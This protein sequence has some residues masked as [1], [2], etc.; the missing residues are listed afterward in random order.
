MVIIYTQCKHE[1]LDC[2]LD[3]WLKDLECN[4]SSDNV[5]FVPGTDVEAC[6]AYWEND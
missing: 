5:W 3:V 6:I 1:Y 2:N 4:G